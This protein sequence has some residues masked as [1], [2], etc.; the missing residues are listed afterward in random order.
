[1]DIGFV[2]WRRYCHRFFPRIDHIRPFSRTQR[3]QSGITFHDDCLLGAKSSSDPWLDDPDF[4]FRNFQ[5]R[6]DNA[7]YMERDLCRTDN[8]QTSKFIQVCIRPERFHH[9][10]LYLFRMV[11]P[12]NHHIGLLERS[13]DIAPIFFCLGNNI[14]FIITTNGDA[15]VPVLFGMYNNRIIYSLME[16]QERFLYVIFHLDHAHSLIYT[17]RI[18]AGYESHRVSDI[19][20]LCIQNK[21]VI[22]TQLRIGLT[23][24]SKPRLGDIFCCQDTFNPGNSQSRFGIN[25]AYDGSCMGA[26]QGFDDKTAF[27]CQILRVSR[28]TCH[29]LQ[30][31]FFHNYPVDFSHKRIPFPFSV[32]YCFRTRI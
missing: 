23:S 6:R 26:A 4:R 19:A 30:G 22:G 10:L 17:C 2:P 12:V 11:R 20:D 18:T 31:I 3:N 29:Q 8:D 5:C 21:P 27:R 32:R 13:I 25:M 16:I 9:R 14:P 7:P 15:G 28:L 1:M 24:N